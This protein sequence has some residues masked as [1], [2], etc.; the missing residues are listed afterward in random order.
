MNESKFC[1]IKNLQNHNDTT[2]MCSS[3]RLIVRNLR[4]SA[5]RLILAVSCLFLVIVCSAM[6][7]SSLHPFP[8]IFR[9]RKIETVYEASGGNCRK[10]SE[11]LGDSCARSL[12]SSTLELSSGTVRSSCFRCQRDVT[13]SLSLS[14]SLPPALKK[15]KEKKKKKSWNESEVSSI[16]SGEQREDA[17]DSVQ[18]VSQQRIGVVWHCCPQLPL[19]DPTVRVVMTPSHR[20]T[21]PLNLLPGLVALYNHLAPLCLSCLLRLHFRPRLLERGR[22]ARKTADTHLACRARELVGYQEASFSASCCSDSVKLIR[23]V[24][25]SLSCERRVCSSRRNV[26]ILFVLATQKKVISTIETCRLNWIFLLWA[27]KHTFA[28]VGDF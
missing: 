16:W 4:L 14:L 2:A 15:R 18:F 12:R 23:A 5:K 20:L 10:V 25:T 7:S 21:S 8:T 28:N 19:V 24:F 6:V 22:I 26:T 9:S 27:M 11:T 13:C 1:F 17:Q 3:L